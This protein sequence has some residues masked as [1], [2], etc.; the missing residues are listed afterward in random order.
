[1]TSEA[2][3]TTRSDR[4]CSSADKEKELRTRVG[5][6]KGKEIPSAWKGHASFVSEVTDS[7]ARV[8]TVGGS[9]ECRRKERESKAAR[10]EENRS[11]R[12]FSVLNFL[13]LH[14][15]T[16]LSSRRNTAQQ[17]LLNQKCVLHNDSRL[18]QRASG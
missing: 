16:C 8:T 11:M 15:P 10:A 2:V 17:V 13:I 14:V 3:Q 9:R 7:N 12:I 1:M 18:D 5:T 4:V 6:E